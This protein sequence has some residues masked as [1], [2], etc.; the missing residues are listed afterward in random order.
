L[1][2]DDWA[3]RKGQRYGTVLVDLENQ[4]PVDL[5][6]DREPSSLVAWLQDHPGVEIISR[7]RG[8]CYT[9]AATEGAPEAIQVADRFH[10]MQNL[11]E[12]LARLIAR[13]SK[14][15]C[16]VVRQRADHQ[17]D[18]DIPNETALI[19]C[20]ESITETKAPTLASQSRR[21][22][23]SEVM[24]LYEQGISQREIA[25]R[26]HLSR[27]TVRRFVQSGSYPERATRPST[28]H[29]DG[30]AGYL[31]DR[32][33]QGCHNVKQL[34][35]EIQDRG[36][37]A[38]YYSVRRRVSA[39]RKHADA[40]R[41]SPPAPANKESP[42]QLSWLVFRNDADL[43]MDQRVF[44]ESVLDQC[45]EIAAGWKIA[46]GFIELFS[47]KVGN[48]LPVWIDEAMHASVPRELRNFAKGVLR[49]S[50]AIAAAIMLPWSNGQTEG[51]VNRLKTLK[52]QM[53]GRGAFDLL[54]LRFLAGA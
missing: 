50:S 13:H 24:T 5:L 44:K 22:R 42:N 2:V 36:F 15:V 4:C 10:L 48:N 35:K 11:R 16:D 8:D 31:W 25:T 34:T 3:F 19:S 51:Q 12:A 29:A 27:S 18:T 41:D 47:V 30:C 39:W 53:Y 40:S 37:T 9:K 28:S 46:N 54:R 38:S 33:K 26:L 20:N 7:D 43:T 21:D 49:D 6:P 52:R 14:E 23:Y 1:G 17:A 32:W 45:P